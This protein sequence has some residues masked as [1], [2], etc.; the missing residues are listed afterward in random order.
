[1]NILSPIATGSGAHIVHKNLEHGINDYTVIPY[2]PYR[3]LFPPSLWPIGRKS[4]PTIVHTTPDYALFHKQR[5]VPLV[6]TF[7]GYVLDQYMSAYSSF[8]QRV[9]YQTDLKWF[10]KLSLGSADKIT[11]VS[12]YTAQ[13][14]EQ[15]QGL[16]KKIQVIYN[17]VDES[18]FVPIKDYKKSS[19]NIRVLFS[20]NLKTSKGAQWLFPILKKLGKNITI[21]YTSGLRGKGALSEHPRLINVGKI[22]HKNMPELYQS[23]DILLFPTVR[24]GLPL[25]V[26]E[27]MA[28]GLP[29]VAT[30][31][32]SLPELIDSG[33]GGFLCGLGD[34]DDFANKINLLAENINLREEMGAY[35]RANVE[36]KFTLNRMVSEYKE[37]FERQ[38][39]VAISKP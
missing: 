8:L 10:T 16:S 26:L 31:C 36:K 27:A 38:L 35:N 30:N 39:D 18:I 1:M 6:L 24:E 23:A 15:D 11:S 22:E 28:C 9:H 25:V 12:N 13:L 19:K 3:T 37:L 2:Q 5:N 33:K 34:V 4:K 14:V 7:H 20:G 32:S 21:L 17:G 29:V